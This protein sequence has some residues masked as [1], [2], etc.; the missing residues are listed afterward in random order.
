VTSRAD[1]AIAPL[2]AELARLDTLPR[3]DQ[4]MAGVLMA[5]MWV[6]MRGFVTTGHVT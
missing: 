1:P 6:D 4:Q 5:E 2:G 3:V